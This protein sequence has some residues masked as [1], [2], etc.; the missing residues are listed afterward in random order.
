MFD[1]FTYLKKSVSQNIVQENKTKTLISHCP[2]KDVI[3]LDI[4]DIPGGLVS[5]LKAAPP[6]PTSWEFSRWSF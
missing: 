6:C 2:E 1:Q 3:N 4:S 5:M